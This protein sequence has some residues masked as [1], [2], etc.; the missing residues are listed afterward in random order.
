M[1]AIVDLGLETVET[2]TETDVRSE[3][4]TMTHTMTYV[5]HAEL[6]Q[7]QFKVELPGA[8]AKCPKT[9]FR[10][11]VCFLDE[12]GK[13][14]EHLRYLSAEFLVSSVWFAQA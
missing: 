11:L 14:M 9:A 7:T 10:L 12:E 5:L 6:S 4:C 2:E 1:S 8:L 13:E 3:S